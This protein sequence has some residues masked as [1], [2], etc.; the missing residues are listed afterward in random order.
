[1]RITFTAIFIAITFCGYTQTDSSKQKITFTKDNF[2]IE[3]PKSW[4]LDTSRIMGTEL[5][6]F[7][8]LEN[9]ADKFSENVNV[10]IQNLSGQNINLEKYKQI[11]EEQLS[12]MATDGKVFESS[13]VKTAKNSFYKIVYAMTQGKLR[14]KISSICFI[15]KDKAYLATFT[16]E[17][18]K[19]DSYQ[20]IANDI[21]STFSITK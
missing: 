3:Y 7:S 15:N 19:Y 13:I 8:P 10:M 4:R 9:E 18:D 17:I 21:L 11:T 12:G 6:I 20:K 5:F 2:K 14:L 16:S 1:M